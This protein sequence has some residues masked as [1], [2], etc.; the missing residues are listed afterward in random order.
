MNAFWKRRLLDN[1][2]EKIYELL[3]FVLNTIETNFFNKESK[4]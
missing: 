4:K 2:E 3:E 1:T